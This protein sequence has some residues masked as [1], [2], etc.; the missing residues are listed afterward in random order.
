MGDGDA[1]SRVYAETLKYGQEDLEIFADNPT[2][3]GIVKTEGASR[4]GTLR[5]LVDAALENESERREENH[6]IETEYQKKVTEYGIDMFSAALSEIPAP[7]SSVVAEGIKI[8]TKEEF[9]FQTY[10]AEPQVKNNQGEWEINEST[11][12]SL[13]SA[14]A[15]RDPAIMEKI[16]EISP[17]MVRTDRNGDYYIPE[18]TRNWNTPPGDAPLAIRESWQAIENEEI[19]PGG[20]TLKDA[21]HHYT[22][23]YNDTRGKPNE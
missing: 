16:M 2:E 10:S 6:K 5:G 3:N 12:I 22:T 1:A 17:G 19:L 18:S 23:T 21:E 11:R 4:S 9:D 14:A 13:L 7:G 8:Y 15:E 20:K